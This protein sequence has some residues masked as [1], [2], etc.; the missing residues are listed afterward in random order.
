VQRRG[1]S[2]HMRIGSAPAA[3]WARCRP[4]P[5]PV[6]PPRR[7]AQRSPRSRRG[8]AAARRVTR[9]SRHHAPGASAR[10]RC[11]RAHQRWGSVPRWRDQLGWRRRRCRSSRALDPGQR[12]GHR[13]RLRSSR[14]RGGRSDQSMVATCRARRA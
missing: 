2:A 4:A 11:R 7:A 9:S 1:L 12:S 5:T 13:A 6:A 8:L 10:R 3:W 14:C